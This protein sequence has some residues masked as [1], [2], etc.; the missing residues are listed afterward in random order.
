M[1]TRF[2]KAFE[3]NTFYD[4]VDL[5]CSVIAWGVSGCILHYS[6]PLREKVSRGMTSGDDQHSS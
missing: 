5:T 6:L 3:E 4:N 2:V 1:F